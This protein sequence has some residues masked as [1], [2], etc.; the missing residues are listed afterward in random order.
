[1][2]RSGRAAT[3]VLLIH[4]SPWLKGSCKSLSEALK[5]RVNSLSIVYHCTIHNLPVFIDALSLNPKLAQ[6]LGVTWTC[7]FEIKTIHD[8]EMQTA[9]AATYLDCVK[10]DMIKRLLTGCGIQALQQLTGIM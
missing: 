10:P 7:C 6:Q 5:F 3:Y 9:G 2:E 8:F 4:L 1:M